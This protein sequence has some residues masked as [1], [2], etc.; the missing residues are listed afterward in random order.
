VFFTLLHVNNLRLKTVELARKIALSLKGPG[1]GHMNVVMLSAS[2]T[3]RLYLPV[4]PRDYVNEKSLWPTR[5]SNPR[6]SRLVAKCLNQPRH[7]LSPYDSGKNV[8]FWNAEPLQFRSCYFRNNNSSVLGN[9]PRQNRITT[10]KY[11]ANRR[12]SQNNGGV[13]NARIF[14][15][16]LNLLYLPQVLKIK[17]SM[18]WSRGICVFCT[19]LWINRKFCLM[20]H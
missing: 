8:K 16:L 6:P 3:Y 10:K 19:G 1:G 20:Q 11:K 2:R 5:E 18:L 7:R 14:L 17:N 4:D 15:T 9:W 12:E 13:R